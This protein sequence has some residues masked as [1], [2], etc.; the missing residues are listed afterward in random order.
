[1]NPGCFHLDYDVLMK[2]ECFQ[3]RHMNYHYFDEKIGLLAFLASNG[4]CF[5]N[6]TCKN[7]TYIKYLYCG[8]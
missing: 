5:S 7:Y 1:M 2:N 3:M 8:Y 4:N 6:C